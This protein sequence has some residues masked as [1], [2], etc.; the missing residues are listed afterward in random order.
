MSD[1]QT[2]CLPDYE[3]KNNALKM[4]YSDWLIVNASKKK[5]S[6]SHGLSIVEPTNL[7]SWRL[8]AAWRSS[9]SENGVGLGAA[10]SMGT[11]EYLL[12]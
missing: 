11:E 5:M 6:S 2:V 7:I 10:N 4:L 1:Q 9:E 12:T 3:N 8:R